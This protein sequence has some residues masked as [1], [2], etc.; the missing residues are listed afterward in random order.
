MKFLLDYSIC[1]FQDMSCVIG[2]SN[3]VDNVNHPGRMQKVRRDTEPFKLLI[4]LI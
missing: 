1:I 2:K 3:G 4:G